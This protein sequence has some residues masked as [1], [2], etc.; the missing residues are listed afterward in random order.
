MRL[1]RVLVNHEGLAYACLWLDEPLR[2]KCGRCNRGVVAEVGIGIKDCLVCG[3]LVEVWTDLAP[4]QRRNL[5][6]VGRERAD[7]H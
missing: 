7:D 3:A 5:L 6:G 2:A 1:P 4:P